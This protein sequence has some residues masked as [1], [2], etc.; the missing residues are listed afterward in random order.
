MRQ[1]NSNLLGE[2]LNNNVLA[3]TSGLLAAGMY[4]HPTEGRVVDGKREQRMDH[5][6]IHFRPDQGTAKI[7]SMCVLH[8][9]LFFALGGKAFVPTYCMECWKVVVKPRTVVQLFQLYDLMKELNYHG[10][11]GFEDREW[12]C[13]NY[14]GYFYLRSK[15]EGLARREEVSAAV[16]KEI[17]DIPVYLKRFCTEFEHKLCPGKTSTYTQPAY[18]K[19]FE[20]EYYASYAVPEENREQPEFLK[21][22]IMLQW[23]AKAWARGDKTAEQLNDGKPLYPATETYNY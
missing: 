17:G 9:N 6:W 20:K 16:K 5:P 11:C 1:I 3:M 18:A 15:A 19:E 13:G 10:K 21:R 12:V 22:Y 23:I 4:I 14:G 8:R 2:L 7:D